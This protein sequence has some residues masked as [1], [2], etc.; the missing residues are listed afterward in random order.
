MRCR[1]LCL[2]SVLCLA[3]LP[4]VAQ[5]DPTAEFGMKPFG[6]FQGGNID[7]VNL[8]NESLNVHIPLVSYPQRGGKLNLGFSVNYYPPTLSYIFDNCTNPDD[9]RTCN[10]DW[11]MTEGSYLN[12][13]TGGGG[14]QIVLDGFPDLA[15][16]AIPATGPDVIVTSDGAP[17]PSATSLPPMALHTPSRG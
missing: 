17:T 2:L 10:E 4:A 14:I 5:D 16:A 3:A 12:Y 1:I 7:N 11:S 9:N 13:L 6:S 15:G 8:L